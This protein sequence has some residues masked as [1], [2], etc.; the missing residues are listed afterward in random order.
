MIFC[1]YNIY[2]PTYNKSIDRYM[3]FLVP[4]A[5]T[6]G[7]KRTSMTYARYLMCVKENR[8][9]KPNEHV[10]HI[11]NDKKDD[12]IE[13]LQILSPKDN[14]RKSAEPAIPIVFK[15]HLCGKE[16]SVRRGRDTNLK[17]RGVAYCSRRCVGLSVH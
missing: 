9:L 5:K 17:N 14:I 13:N 11:N 10:D 3:A 1:E 4:R 6:S 2:G 8:W 15:C 12:R 16:K 7:L